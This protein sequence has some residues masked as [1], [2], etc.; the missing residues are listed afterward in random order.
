MI[1]EL[2]KYLLKEN[3]ISLNDRIIVAISGGCDS[4]A[5]ALLL[6]E[7]GFKIE[8][9]HCNFKL[10]GIDSDKDEEFVRNFSLQN[11]VPFH[12]KSFNTKKYAEKKGF[13]DQMAARELRYSWFNEL[14]VKTN[15]KYIAVAHHLED[16]I[17]TFLINFVRGSGIR[18][19]LG[20]HLIRDDII[21]PLIKYDKEDIQK[22]LS[23]KGQKY[24]I[25]ISNFDNKYLRNNI[26][27]NIIPSLKEINPSFN[28]T[29]INEMSYLNEV[30]E[31]F[32]DT[33]NKKKSEIIIC[34][35]EKQFIDIK[36]LMNSKFSNAILREILYP[37]GFKQINKIICSIGNTGKLF[38]SS[39]HLLLVD[40]HHLILSKEDKLELKSKYI[41]KFETS[42]NQPLNMAFNVT[43]DINIIDD[44]SFA[45]FDFEKL[46]FPLEI[47]KW[48][49]GDTFTP[50]GMN[51]NKKIS[52]YFVDEKWNRFDKEEC[53]LLL[54]RN[55]IIWIIGHRI[56]EKF[57]ITDKTKKAYIANLF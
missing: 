14:K 7:I 35:G 30:Y 49:N 16:N 43:Q 11:G 20:M 27:N 36:K 21:R 9:A 42:I 23:D 26:R 34:N 32:I 44:K 54:S 1:E 38:Y 33:I 56:S 25:D 37:Y 8:L 17:E 3:S 22:Y 4:V 47:R 6:I 2:K 29:F 53:L 40:R 48:K 15:S 41:D 52:D 39:T 57:K 10:R 5:L 24:R 12:S 28:N 19:F 51:G 55:E 13:S 50:L 31:I 46:E 18:G 45:F